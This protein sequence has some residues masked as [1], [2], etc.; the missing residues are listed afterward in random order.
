MGA[1]VVDLVDRWN[2]RS[3][4]GFTYHVVHPGGR[5]YDT[6]PVNAV[7]AESRRAS[8]FRT[9]GHTP[10]PIDPEAWP[11]L[12][13]TTRDAGSEYPCTL[14]LRRFDPGRRGGADPTT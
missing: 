6:Y 9:T 3:L 4:G 11:R 14:D 7:E 2:S 1:L 12:A 13:T 10:G 8:R 5:S